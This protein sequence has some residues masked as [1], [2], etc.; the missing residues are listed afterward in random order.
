MLV[1]FWRGASF[2]A[3]SSAHVRNASSPVWSHAIHSVPGQ[4][5]PTQSPFC[6]YTHFSNFVPTGNPFTPGATERTLSTA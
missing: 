2:C 4:N 6:E 5:P 3:D 1:S